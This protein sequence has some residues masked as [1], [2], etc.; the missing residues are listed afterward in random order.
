MGTQENINTAFEKI[1]SKYNSKIE[2]LNNSR[3]DKK[4]LIS[5]ISNLLTTDNKF[6]SDFSKIKQ[7][8]I[9]SANKCEKL[10]YQDF[11]SIVEICNSING[12]MHYAVE[13]K[14]SGRHGGI[15]TLKDVSEYS[16][17][18]FKREMNIVSVNVDYN[19]C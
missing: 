5:K 17:T 19:I 2:S 12:L 8:L 1:E 16:E 4:L 15:M 9:F 3:T 10:S 18:E 6:V 14:F 11:I 13:F 7:E